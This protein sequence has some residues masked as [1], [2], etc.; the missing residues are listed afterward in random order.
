MGRGTSYVSDRPRG[1]VPDCGPSPWTGCLDWA[2]GPA[3]TAGHVADEGIDVSGSLVGL[4]LGATELRGV[5]VNR[6][7]GVVTHA[8]RVPVP[9]G[10]FRH[11]E[12]AD[13]KGLKKALRQLWRSGRFT[14]RRVAFALPDT[15]AL[16]RQ[17][18]LPWMAPTDFRASLRWQVGES[19]PVDLDTVELDYVP[20]S[21]FSSHDQHGQEVRMQ[22]CLVVAS[23]T[24]LVTS[25]C[26]ALTAAHLEPTAADVASLALLRA[27]T[28]TY[29]RAESELHALVDI[30][31]RDVTV[32]LHTGEQPRFIR[33]LPQVGGDAIIRGLVNGLG[34]DRAEACEILMRV[35]LNGPPP[36]VAPVA[37]SSVFAALAPTT[38]VA[39]DP[40]VSAALA[41]IQPWATALVGSIRDSLDYYQSASRRGPASSIRL[42]GRLSNLD[43]LRERVS[44]E[45]KTP[46]F[47]TDVSQG[48][49]WSARAGKVD[50]TTLSLALGLALRGG[51]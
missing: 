37:E 8:A 15:A 25:M 45:L 43:G 48:L 36:P 30:G 28:V 7:K 35:G 12:I 47:T 38:A 1:L 14:T 3:R 41:I 46:T 18:D 39:V 49:T 34:I 26:S 23:S 21:T 40:K 33:A 22:R 50:P 24:S 11:G 20:L 19:L 27:V 4:D 42:S 10:I 32:V 13:P 51:A 31:A 44:T 9:E 17:L 6:R 29:P 2:P 5:Q 16:T